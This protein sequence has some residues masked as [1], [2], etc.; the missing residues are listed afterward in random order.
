MKTYLDNDN[1]FTMH[2]H[3]LILLSFIGGTYQDDLQLSR[4]YNSLPT[5]F[6]VSWLF[7]IKDK[8]F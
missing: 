5:T 6:V 3:L 1:S 2:G 8:M 4:L 7:K